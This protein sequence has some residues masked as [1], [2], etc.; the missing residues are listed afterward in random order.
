Q[1]RKAMVV[2]EALRQRFFGWES[3]QD[4][5]QFS[6]DIAEEAIAAAFVLYK[7]TGDDRF[8]LAALGFAERNKAR[9][10]S[11]ELRWTLSMNNTSEQDSLVRKEK[12]LMQ[13]AAYYE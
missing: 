8:A 4:H 3:K 10:L 6:L 12:E 2:S 13:A 1:Y 9:I 7:Q 5:Q 11:D